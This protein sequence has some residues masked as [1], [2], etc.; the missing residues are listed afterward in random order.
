MKSKTIQFLL[1]AVMVLYMA[2]VILS[3]FL[4]WDWIIARTDVIVL[5]CIF[6]SVLIALFQIKK[7]P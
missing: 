4:Q 5:C 1:T 7:A 2:A 6:Y 3:D